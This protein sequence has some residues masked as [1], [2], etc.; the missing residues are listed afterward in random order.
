MCKSKE[1]DVQNT[2]IKVPQWTATRSK[3]QFDASFTWHKTEHW[4]IIRVHLYK[5]IKIYKNSKNKEHEERVASDERRVGLSHTKCGTQRLRAA[6]LTTMGSGR[7]GTSDVKK[8]TM[9]RSNMMCMGG[10]LSS[11]SVS[12]VVADVDSLTSPR[13]CCSSG[14]APSCRALF[15]SATLSS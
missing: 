3:L 11:S 5:T 9:K 2:K 15:S 13:A 1:F 4:K 14:A 8:V 10:S 7:A 12:V 6:Q